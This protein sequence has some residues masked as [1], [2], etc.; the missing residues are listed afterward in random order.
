M[1]LSCDWKLRQ[2]IKILH[3]VSWAT[4]VQATERMAGSAIRVLIA[5]VAC[6]HQHYC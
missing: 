6:G 5:Q 4:L 3:H 1:F 2:D